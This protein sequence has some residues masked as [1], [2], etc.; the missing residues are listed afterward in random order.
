M[1]NLYVYLHAKNN[2]SQTSQTH[3]EI[4]HFKESCSLIGLEHYSPSIHPS[5][6]EKNFKAPMKVLYTCK[7]QDNPSS[8]FLF[9]VPLRILQ[10]DWLS[11][12]N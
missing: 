12:Y 7:K 10:F 4:L 9:I 1:E 11:G 3:H 5:E 8:I 6:T 2:S